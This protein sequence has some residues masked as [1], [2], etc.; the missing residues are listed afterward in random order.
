MNNIFNLARNTVRGTADLCGTSYWR[1]SLKAN[2]RLK[3]IY[4]VA[5]THNTT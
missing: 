1:L 3:Y 5:I 4:I 2:T